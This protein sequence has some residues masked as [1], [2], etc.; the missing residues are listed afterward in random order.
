MGS[1]NCTVFQML[2]RMY[3]KVS[4]S[5]ASLVS[6]FVWGGYAFSITVLMF[7]EVVA[8]IAK[9]VF[10]RNLKLVTKIKVLQRLLFYLVPMYLTGSV[11][12]ILVKMFF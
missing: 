7:S 5:F 4:F 6:E 11:I 1:V 2:L 8:G 9:A 12:V 3:C 10:K